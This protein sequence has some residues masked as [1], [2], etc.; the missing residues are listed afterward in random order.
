[1]GDER[2]GFQSPGGRIWGFPKRR[3][4]LCRKFW[5]RGKS[6]RRGKLECA[7]ELAG[8]KSTIQCEEIVWLN[9]YDITCLI[10]QSTW[11]ELNNQVM[12]TFIH[13]IMVMILASKYEH[14]IPPG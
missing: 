5:L 12:T 11:I 9:I 14:N 2:G 4:S 10:N 6:C 8:T 1:M 3:G 7:G 13:C